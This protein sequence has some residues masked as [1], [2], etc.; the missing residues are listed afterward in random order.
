[1]TETGNPVQCRTCGFLIIFSENNMSQTGV[2]I[3]MN[4][5]NNKF[6]GKGTNHNC[7]PQYKAP[8]P[9]EIDM[10]VFCPSCLTEYDRRIVPW[11]PCCFKLMCL[12]CNSK[13]IATTFNMFDIANDGEVL[14]ECPNCGSMENEKIEDV[15]SWKKAWD[16][17]EEMVGLLKCPRCK[18]KNWIG[19]APL[20]YRKVIKKK[21]DSNS[22]IVSFVEDLP[23][24]D[25]WKT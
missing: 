15:E 8:D 19:P 13:W 3:P 17:R 10:H 18:G 21:K 22:V 20:V 12:E 7:R 24:R 11:C 4:F 14:R 6:G 25:W 2:L 16:Q 1:M 9:S 5:S 23:Y